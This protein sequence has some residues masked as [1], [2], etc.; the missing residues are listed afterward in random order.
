MDMLYISVESSCTFR[1]RQRFIL[2]I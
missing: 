1:N 2:N